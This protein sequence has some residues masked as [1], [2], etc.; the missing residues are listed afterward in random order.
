MELDYWVLKTASK[1]W[2]H[3]TRYIRF[4]FNRD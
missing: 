4:D 3:G 1:D 2:R